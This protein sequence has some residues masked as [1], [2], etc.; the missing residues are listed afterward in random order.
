IPGGDVPR[1]TR[2]NAVRRSNRVL[3]TGLSRAH[4]PRFCRLEMYHNPEPVTDLTTPSICHHQPFSLSAHL[5]DP[6]EIHTVFQYKIADPIL[7]TCVESDHALVLLRFT[8]RLIGH[9]QKSPQLARHRLRDPSVCA[10]Y[11]EKLGQELRQTRHSG[12]D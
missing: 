7:T 5:I 1:I 11:E 2:H 9:R 8:L 6:I 3:L 10:R 4:A 12:V